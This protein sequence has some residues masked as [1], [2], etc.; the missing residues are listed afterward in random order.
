MRPSVEEQLKGT[1]RV[2]ETVVSPHVA[3]PFAQSILTGLIANL[4]MLTSAFPAVAGFLRYDNRA[5]A[6]L[7]SGL[8]EAMT[9]DLAERVSTVLG[10][11][12]PDVA[13]P[14]ALQERNRILREM[15]AE[16]VCSDDLTPAHHEAIVSHM[17][18]YAARMPMRYVPTAPS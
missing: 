16:A 14:V 9:Q 1:C 7:L 2:L 8:R 5:T 6:T 10:D 3:E 18:D 15:L 13:D 11:P 12:E 17:S 4:R